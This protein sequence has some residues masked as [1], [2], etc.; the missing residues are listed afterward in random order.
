MSG[1][2]DMTDKPFLDLYGKQQ[3]QEMLDLILLPPRI[4]HLPRTNSALIAHLLRTNHALIF[5]C[6][7]VCIIYI[8]YNTVELVQNKNL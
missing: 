2:F 8:V 5:A 7:F 1:D 6:D 4:T 3:T